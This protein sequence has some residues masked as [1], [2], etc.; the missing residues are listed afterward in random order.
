MSAAKA[1]NDRTIEI[2]N[3]II[4]RNNRKKE[5][6]S[7]LFVSKNIFSRKKTLTFGQP[8][9]GII[10]RKFYDHDGSCGGEFIT[11]DSEYLCWF[12]GV[13]AGYCGEDKDKL[14]KILDILREGH[15]LEMWIE[16]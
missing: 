13:L 4:E 7:T 12:E 2:A 16:T 6:S 11:I 9:K 5:M 10:A 1:F 14:E 8:I 3:L 15:S